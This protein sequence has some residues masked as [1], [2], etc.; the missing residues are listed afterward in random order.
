ME[1]KGGVKVQPVSHVSHMCYPLLLPCS[2]GNKPRTLFVPMARALSRSDALAL[3]CV[4]VRDTKELQ[5]P[6]KRCPNVPTLAHLCTSGCLALSP[7]FPRPQRH[8]HIIAS[9]WKRRSQGQQP[10]SFPTSRY[11]GL[12]DFTFETADYF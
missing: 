6:L 11:L 8:C 4:S 1:T 5:Q 9:S 3:M 10:T 12:L 2:A 7:T